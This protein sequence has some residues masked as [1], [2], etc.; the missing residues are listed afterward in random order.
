MNSSKGSSHLKGEE[1]SFTIEASLVFP[2]ILLSLCVL[3]FFC[4]LLYQ[5]SALLQYASAA[6]ERASY[7]WDNS[8]KDAKTGSYPEGET[9]PLYWCFA[10]DHMIGALFGSVSGGQITTIELPGGAASDDLPMKKLSQSGAGLPVLYRGQ[11]EYANQMLDRQVWTKL[12]QNMRLPMLDF[13]FSGDPRIQH[14]G[15]ST[16]V[17]PDEFI[18]NVE[19]MRYYGARFSRMGTPGNPSEFAQILQKFAG[20]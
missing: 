9:D 4:V 13:L 20:M 3:M 6:S 18:R 2:V 12:N 1:G 19:L 10:D 7:S 5:K 16:V 8:H 11:M 17:E 15:K 14:S